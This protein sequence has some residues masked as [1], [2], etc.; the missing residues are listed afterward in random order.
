MKENI[1]NFDYRDHTKNPRE[2]VTIRD[3]SIYW[4]EISYSD[5]YI[6]YNR[7]Y[8]KMLDI[9]GNVYGISEII[10]FFAVFIFSF[11]SRLGLNSHLCTR[12]LLLEEDD[13]TDSKGNKITLTEK[14]KFQSPQNARKKL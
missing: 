4:A 2:A 5:K 3:E 11:Y 10:V 6:H 8:Q 7:N 1:M 14:E 12:L 9:V 13:S